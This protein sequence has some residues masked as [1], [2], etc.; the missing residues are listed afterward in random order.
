M[1]YPIYFF[2]VNILIAPEF[3]STVLP[4]TNRDQLLYQL[5]N[6]TVWVDGVPR[7]LRHGDCFTLSGE[8]AL[9]VRRL[10]VDQ[11]NQSPFVLEM[12]EIPN[13]E[14]LALTQNDSELTLT[15]TGNSSFFTIVEVI[16]N[17]GQTTRTQLNKGVNTFTFVGSV[18]RNTMRLKFGDGQGNVSREFAVVSAVVDPP[19]SET[20]TQL[21]GQVFGITQDYNEN[22]FLEDSLYEL[23]ET[24][25]S[26][27]QTFLAKFTKPFLKYDS[28][29]LALNPQN[30]L[31]YIFARKEVEINDNGDTAT[32]IVLET[33][34][35]ST[36]V[37]TTINGDITSDVAQIF[38]MT[39]YDGHFIASATNNETGVLVTVSLTGSVSQLAITPRNIYG[40]IVESGV[41]YGAVPD[42]TTAYLSTFNPDTGAGT[43]GPINIDFTNFPD[44]TIADHWRNISG[45]GFDDGFFIALMVLDETPPAKVRFD[46]NG[47]VS[48]VTNLPVE[49]SNLVITPTKTIAV[50]ETDNDDYTVGQIYRIDVLPEEE[51]LMLNCIESD[52][53]ATLACNPYDGWIYRFC[54]RVYG[55]D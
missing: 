23:T 33:L 46:L 15:W 34:N 3:L 4:G 37:I 27:V 47:L 42:G 16:D 38:S 31:I 50:V 25:E 14:N 12:F 28:Y 10:Y 40:L 24:E 6:K 5:R 8:E 49:M 1:A 9:R 2:R 19:E 11:G 13:V 22:E 36:G 52:D 39:Y 55:D 21:D 26:F 51:I 54:L 41:L 18:G 7:P 53:S 29:G 30:G 45:L 32:N 48:E 43:G 20:E 17:D 35:I 44:K